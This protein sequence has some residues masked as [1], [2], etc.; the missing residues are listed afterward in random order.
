[1]ELPFKKVRSMDE[2]FC[3]PS[4][5]S[6]SMDW[7]RREKCEF[8]PSGGPHEL[9]D[10]GGEDQCIYCKRIFGQHVSDEDRT[11]HSAEQDSIKRAETGKTEQSLGVY[12]SEE[13]KNVSQ[14]HLAFGETAR[15][16]IALG[17]KDK[18]LRSEREKKI[19]KLRKD[20]RVKWIDRLRIPGQ[21]KDN[22]EYFWNEFLNGVEQIPSDAE[23]GNCFGAVMYY[24]QR[25]LGIVISPNIIAK[26]LG[27]SDRDV[28]SKTGCVRLALEKRK[29]ELNPNRDVVQ[30]NSVIND[31]VGRL[32]Q[33]HE[34]SEYLI[35][36]SVEV[37]NAIKKPLQGRK[38]NTVS[39]LAVY[40]ACCYNENEKFRPLAEKVLNFRSEK[41]PELPT[42]STILLVEKRCATSPSINTIKKEFSNIRG[43]DYSLFEKNFK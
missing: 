25:S 1:M 23:A 26:Q 24:S 3:S 27:L 28:I 38:I 20:A 35:R 39:A 8:N 11:T 17:V 21:Q 32:G 37:Y 31:Y 15:N 41:E 33:S 29:V 30:D 13:A 10:V 6:C 34:D 4:G 14:Q 43:I 5:Y 12:V 19:G 7:R 16:N 42:K 18:D 9:Q 36:V 22:I 40:M 2:G